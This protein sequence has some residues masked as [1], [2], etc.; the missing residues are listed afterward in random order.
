[1]ATTTTAPSSVG[2]R[3]PLEPLTVEEIARTVEILRAERQLGSRVRFVSISLHEPPKEKVLAF[4]MA[5]S[6]D[7][8]A[9]VILLD[10][11]LGQVYEAVVS[12]ST[13]RGASWERIEGV[14][15]AIMLDEFLECEQA[16]KAS[17]E[18]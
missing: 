8:E 12:L 16:C 3:H 15:P 9:F 10:N 6:V 5:G 14:Q 18:W 13:G 11:E 1:M 17:P 7:R 2:I 4:P